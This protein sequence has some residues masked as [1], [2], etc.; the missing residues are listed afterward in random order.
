MSSGGRVPAEK[1]VNVVL[2]GLGWELKYIRNQR[3]LSLEVVCQ[4][5]RWQQ[6][7]LS[8]ME[9]G[10]Q[11]ISDADLASLLVIYEVCSQERRQLLRLAQRQDAPG[12]WTLDAPIKTVPFK[13][14]ELEAT[15]I[16]DAQTILMPGLAQTADYALAMM[17]PLNVPAEEAKRRV[18]E[19][20]ARKNILD[21]GK[22][23]NFD[24]ILDEVAL[25]RP[26]G[27][28]A[29]MAGQLRALLDLAERP[30]VRLWV[31]PMEQSCDAG[32]HNSFYMLNFA[33]NQSV[34]FLEGKESNLYLED[35]GK[36]EIFRRHASRLGQAALNPAESVDFVARIRKDHERK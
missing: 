18:E 19:R 35:D 11:H 4:Q 36:I 17:A 32:F 7:K 31:L 26:V 8:R 2:S 27:G 9:N 10:Q 14:L 16:V 25:R 23:P 3:G 24:M 1:L 5:L 21:R 15:S 6:S 22:P 33:R 12:Y 29:V 34:V 13:R 20:M 30:N 28:H